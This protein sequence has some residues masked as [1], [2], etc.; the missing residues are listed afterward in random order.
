LNWFK[1]VAIDLS[2]NCC[3]FGDWCNG[4]PAEFFV[5]VVDFFLY[6]VYSPGVVVLLVVVVV[7]DC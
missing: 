1:Y 5:E 4:L 7:V 2:D 3:A 6:V